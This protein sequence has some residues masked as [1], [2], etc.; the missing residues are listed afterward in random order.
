M[1]ETVP[2]GTFGQGSFYRMEW[3]SPADRRS[4]AIKSIEF[5]SDGSCVAILI[6]I[7][8]IMEW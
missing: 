7:T 6:A 2:S 3:S 8:G 4:V 5:S 1:A